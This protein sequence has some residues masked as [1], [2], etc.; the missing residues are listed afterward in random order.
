M[1]AT[2]LNMLF[3]D[4]IRNFAHLVTPKKQ[5][6]EEFL[7]TIKRSYDISNPKTNLFYQ[8]CQKS[9]FNTIRLNRT[10]DNI[11]FNQ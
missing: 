1:E 6:K 3:I 9:L 10:K 2:N 11:L 5:T 7:D 4:Q 8:S